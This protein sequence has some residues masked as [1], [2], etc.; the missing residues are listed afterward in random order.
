ML[1]PARIPRTHFSSVFSMFA[2]SLHSCLPLAQCRGLSAPKHLP[3]VTRG[4]FVSA[5]HLFERIESIN[6]PSLRRFSHRLCMRIGT[7]FPLWRYCD[8]IPGL[9]A[10]EPR[11]LAVCL[12]PILDF[13]WIDPRFNDR[14]FFKCHEIT[15]E[16]KNGGDAH[17]TEL[18]ACLPALHC[19]RCVHSAQPQIAFLSF[20]SDRIMKRATRIENIIIRLLLSRLVL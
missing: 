17:M 7:P 1:C 5:E 4:V 15:T 14:T 9:E 19:M 2:N 18:C 16:T 12:S 6:H 13:R 10:I 3:L 8:N 20:F 11:P